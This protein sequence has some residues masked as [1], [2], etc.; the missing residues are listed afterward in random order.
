MLDQKIGHTFRIQKDLSRVRAK[1]RDLFHS[2][3]TSI[4][5]KVFEQFTKQDNVNY[6]KEVEWE[7]R[8][9]WYSFKRKMEKVYAERTRSVYAER[10]RSED[11]PIEDEVK[12]ICA[13]YKSC[14]FYTCCIGHERQYSNTQPIENS[15]DFEKIYI[16]LKTH[17]MEEG[18]IRTFEQIPK[19]VAMYRDVV[20]YYKLKQA[21]EHE[22]KDHNKINR[23]YNIILSSKTTEDHPVEWAFKGIKRVRKEMPKDTH[24][25]GVAIIR[26][27]RKL[28]KKSLLLSR[29]HAR[30]GLEFFDSHYH[31]R[32]SEWHR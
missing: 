1:P 19:C 20:T 25:V 26:L 6:E 32:W 9:R 7:R 8:W 18:L 5:Y 29:L 12:H 10:T 24:L 27:R 15:K 13:I 30:S 23:I 17:G 28:G 22:P 4:M 3:I 11:K 16:I 2:D 14:C 31:H 21:M